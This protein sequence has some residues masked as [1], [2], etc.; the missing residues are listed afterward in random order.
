[1]NHIIGRNTHITNKPQT[2]VL[3][4]YRSFLWISLQIS[5]FDLVALT[6]PHTQV[7]LQEYADTHPLPQWQLLFTAAFLSI[8]CVLKALSNNHLEF[9]KWYPCSVWLSGLCRNC[10]LK[11]SYPD[12]FVMTPYLCPTVHSLHRLVVLKLPLLNIGVIN[13]QNPPVRQAYIRCQDKIYMLGFMSN[14]S[15]QCWVTCKFS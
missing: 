9:P 10:I 6:L 5:V 3:W 2:C 8:H 14:S 12:Q 7:M 13:H 1:M 4:N 15:A 11:C